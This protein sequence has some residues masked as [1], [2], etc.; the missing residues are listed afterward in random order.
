MVKDLIIQP[1]FDWIT[2]A[3][4]PGPPIHLTQKL[5]DQ[6]GAVGRV[7]I[8][9]PPTFIEIP[10][11]GQLSFDTASN[12]AERIDRF[13]DHLLKETIDF[14]WTGAAVALVPL[15]GTEAEANIQ[16]LVV[17]WVMQLQVTL[18][19]AEEVTRQSIEVPPNGW[20]RCM[21]SGCDRRLSQFLGDDL[22]MLVLITL[23]S[24][25]A[26]HNV[27]VGCGAQK[28]AVEQEVF[29]MAMDHCRRNLVGEI[30]NKVFLDY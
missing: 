16:G 29:W 23:K 25:T 11:A 2:S 17:D 7:G 6:S 9:V 4:R 12:N 14:A 20:I 10:G 24:D 21:K 22:V 28:A 5:R 13:V 26:N 15:H 3:T 19:P 1:Y 30:V 27:T 8:V 18:E